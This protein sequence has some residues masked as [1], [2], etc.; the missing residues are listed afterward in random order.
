MTIQERQVKNK[1]RTDFEPHVDVSD[2][3]HHNHET[4]SQMRLSRALAAMTVAANTG[5]SAVESC[6]TVVDESG[7]CGI[8]AVGISNLQNK[9]FIVQAK[10]GSGNASQTDVLK[11]CNGLR[12]FFYGEWESLGSKIRHRRAEIDKALDNDA[13]VVAIF[14]HLG[15]SQPPSESK[16]VSDSLL[17]DINSS[18]DILKFEYYGLK[19]NFS[20]RNVA[21]GLHS[22]DAEL[23]FDNWTT[24]S[25]F[26]LEILGVVGGE[27]LAEI[28]NRF[29]DKLFNK[30]IRSFLQNTETNAGLYK[31]IEESP[32]DFWAYNNGITIMAERV[33]VPG[34]A[35]PKPGNET[36]ALHGVSVVNGAQTCGAIA[37][38]GQD[39]I[40]LDEVKVTVRVISSE[41]HPKEFEQRVTRFTNT[42]NNITS[43]EFVSL[44]KYHADLKESLLDENI[45]YL[46]RTGEVDDDPKYN[47]SFTLDDATRALACYNSPELATRAKREISKMWSD[48]NSNAYQ[49]LFPRDQSAAVVYNCVRFWRKMAKLSKDVTRDYGQ[50]RQNIAENAMFVTTFFALEHARRSRFS[51]EDVDSNL[52]DFFD[53]NSSFISKIITLAVEVH[54]D[55]NPN[56]YALSFFKNLSKVNGLVLE[57]RRRIAMS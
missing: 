26:K 14:T 28:V 38:A 37:K 52:D 31:T 8:D 40:P 15:Q 32:Q 34:R 12:N 29:N 45:L 5:L 47:D 43:R 27:N 25:G 30:N 35:K 6:Y 18:G 19:E 21:R 39:G 55:M 20:N 23:E 22:I 53:D 11:F 49:T 50:R 16:S 36:F 10:T 3:L 54:E 44:D 4:I 24:P 7:D 56:G 46:Y 41:D 17:K 2:I 13:E 51:F 48:T 42:Q 33:S 1:L 9:I 57:V